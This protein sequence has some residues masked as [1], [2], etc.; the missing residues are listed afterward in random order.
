MVLVHPI[1]QGQAAQFCLRRTLSG[2]RGDMHVAAV[3]QS[4]LHELVPDCVSHE[5]ST[6]GEIELILDVATMRID[7]LGTEVEKSGNLLGRIPFGNEQ[8]HSTL[9]LGEGRLWQGALRR[10][11]L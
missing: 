3:G 9:A 8:D 4:W 10:I 7:G 2:T 6:F 1:A 5:L 11:F